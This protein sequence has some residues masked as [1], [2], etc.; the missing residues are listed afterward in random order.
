MIVT[1]VLVTVSL[2]TVLAVAAS[3]LMTRRVR[4]SRGRGRLCLIAAPVLLVGALLLWLNT[5][6]LQAGWESRSWPQVPG[7]VV[8]TEISGD[9]VY[10]PLITYRY[11]VGGSTYTGESTGHAP[12]FGGKRKR[13]DAADEIVSHYPPGS[14][15]NVYYEPHDPQVSTLTPGPS[16]DVFGQLGLGGTLYLGGL[17]CL[18]AALLKR[19]GGQKKRPSTDSL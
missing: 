12:G 3:L 5:G 18:L 1:F 17:I 2:L 9:R 13:F 4:L 19:S 16:W 10:A 7:E 6:R 8:S 14:K 11:A 15:L